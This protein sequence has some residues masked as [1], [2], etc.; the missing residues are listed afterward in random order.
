[1][2]ALG[3]VRGSEEVSFS[4]LGLVELL[5]TVPRGVISRLGMV[6]GGVRVSEGSLVV[7]YIVGVGWVWVVSV[8][9]R[10]ET[11]F[12]CSAGFLSWGCPEVLIVIHPIRK[13][14]VEIILSLVL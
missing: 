8:I 14:H 11:D 3:L 2:V 4:V 13:V 1:M 6:A 7:G 9:G 10:S 12:G 5:P